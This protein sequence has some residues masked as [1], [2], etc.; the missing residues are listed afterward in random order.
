[1]D[2]EL[3][4]IHQT[5]L[6]PR[7][8]GPQPHIHQ[9]AL[10]LFIPQIVPFSLFRHLVNFHKSGCRATCF[11]LTFLLEFLGPQVL[12]FAFSKTHLFN[13][14]KHLFQY[15]TIFS[16]SMQTSLPFL[17][18]AFTSSQGPQVCIS[19]YTFYTSHSSFCT[20]ILNIFHHHDITS[21]LPITFISCHISCH[22]YKHNTVIKFMTHRLKLTINPNLM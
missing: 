7:S 10:L 18:F 20:F 9:N 4:I 11:P 14:Q 16:I 17:I 8:I 6:S 19:C 2:A 3:H 15:L 1:V 21:P 22:L 5:F 12:Q 13:P